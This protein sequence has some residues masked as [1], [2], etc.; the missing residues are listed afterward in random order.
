MH[1]DNAARRLDVTPPRSPKVGAERADSVAPVQGGDVVR[2]LSRAERN[3]RASALD[4]AMS[5]TRTSGAMLART[6]GVDPTIARD[7]RHGLRP[8]TD[9][10]IALFGERLRAAYEAALAG[11]CR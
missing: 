6:L 2:F 11:P 1:R 5:E 9:E 8:L 3:L 7:I 10:R 4:A